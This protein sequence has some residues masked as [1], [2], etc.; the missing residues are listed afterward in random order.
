MISLSQVIPLEAVIASSIKA[1]RHYLEL[2]GVRMGED[3]GAR[4]SSIPVLVHV[5]ALL[6]LLYMH[7]KQLARLM[8]RQ[9]FQSR[10]AF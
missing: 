10:Q 7:H 8:F 5:G 1:K 2:I 3:N 6:A 9:T 4:T